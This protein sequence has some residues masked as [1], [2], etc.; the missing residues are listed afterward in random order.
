MF[1]GWEMYKYAERELELGAYIDTFKTFRIPSIIK[2][3]SRINPRCGFGY[4]LHPPY[5][6]RLY[7]R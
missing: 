3:T 5:L 4:S 7:L 2:S 6:H 1:H